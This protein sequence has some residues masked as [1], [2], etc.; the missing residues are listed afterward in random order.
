M[1]SLL[2]RAV[3]AIE[4]IAQDIS[5]MRIEQKKMIE[6]SAQSTLKGEQVATELIGQFTNL[7]TKGGKQ[8]GN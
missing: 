8:I 4:S 1:F 3:I 2:K 7:F 6:F 5:E